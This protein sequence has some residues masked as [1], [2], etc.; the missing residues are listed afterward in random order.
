[1]CAVLQEETYVCF[2]IDF[3]LSGI[4]ASVPQGSSKER[5][6]LSLSSSTAYHLVAFQ[7]ESRFTVSSVAGGTSF[8]IVLEL[9]LCLNIQHREV[10]QES[11][12]HSEV[13]RTCANANR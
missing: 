3:A 8:R 12:V 10:Y 6:I 1:M 2:L 13:Y 9:G 11:R 4:I 7:S 5:D